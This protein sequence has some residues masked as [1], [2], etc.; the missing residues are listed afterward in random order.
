M[1]QTPDTASKPGL[2]NRYVTAACNKM[3]LYITPEVDG[4]LNGCLQEGNI[5]KLPRRTLL[6]APA[7]CQTE[8]TQLQVLTQGSM[9]V[10]E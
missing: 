2:K 9:K 10:L 4:T 7:H 6:L 1:V 3:K 5:I 8:E